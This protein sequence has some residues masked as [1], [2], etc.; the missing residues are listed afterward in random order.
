MLVVIS[1]LHFTDGTAGE[2]NLPVEAF[3]DVFLSDTMEDTLKILQDSCSCPADLPRVIPQI[4]RTLE[5]LE[6]RR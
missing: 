5:G 6:E 2:H 3:D 4:G 1:D